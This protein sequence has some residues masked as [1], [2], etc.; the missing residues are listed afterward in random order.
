MSLSTLKDYEWV[1]VIFWEKTKQNENRR[2]ALG[3]K[4][5]TLDLTS[6]YFKFMLVIDFAKSSEGE[7]VREDI[8]CK[9]SPCRLFI[10]VIT[11]QVHTCVFLDT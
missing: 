5:L 2:V 10:F 7:F 1:A 9:R 6:F 3:A 8:Q 4:M 11:V